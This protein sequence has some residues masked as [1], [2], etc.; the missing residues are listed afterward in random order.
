[1]SL[2]QGEPG[3][4]QKRIISDMKIRTSHA[5]IFL[6]LA[7]SIGPVFAVDMPA[8][9]DYP[10]HLAVMSV[11]SRN[12]TPAENPF[13][14][15]AWTFNTNLAMELVVPPLGRLIGLG[16]AGKAFLLLSQ[17]LV[18]GG[19]MAI[20]CV[21]RGRLELSPFAAALFLYSL[22]FAWGFLNFE[23]GLG[24]ALCAIAVWLRTELRPMFVRA[25]V[26]SIFVIVMFIAHLFALGIYGA[27]LGLHELW[28]LRSGRAPVRQTLLTMG[29]LAAPAVVVFG[30]MFTLGH[31]IA[32]GASDT[33]WWF[34]Y[35]PR[36]V[37]E[38]MNG[39]SELLSMAITALIIFAALVS[40]RRG[41]LKLVGSGAWIS[42]GFAVLYIA[43]P[44]RLFDAAFNDVRVV[45][46]AGLILPS[47]VQLS[48]AN[49]AWRRTAFLTAA[50]CAAANLAVVW[51]VWLSFRP[52]YAAIILSFQRITK[53]STVLVA[54]SYPAAQ[55]GGWPADYPF[56]HAPTLAVA[57]ANALVPSLFTVPGDRPAT[58]RPAYRQF[59]QPALYPAPE[60]SAL[61]GIAA[62]AYKDSPLYLQSWPRKYD[63]VYVLGP[64]VLNPM[65]LVLH[66]LSA[67]SRFVLYQVDK[68]AKMP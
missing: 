43:M 9:L 18:I 8:M 35:K 15:V 37:F 52:D 63:F 5:I 58:L 40:A 4:A 66:E 6:L 64:R 29:V 36:W 20:E 2:D 23:F 3:A 61:P 53:N 56:Y 17:L 30:I 60:V 46:A 10:N 44:G 1:M 50:G 47:F 27:T 26:H 39:Y 7:L 16:V 65:P 55:P 68:A 33:Q 19:A 48:F 45:T 24:V 49:L 38:A 31:S 13:Y 51:W 59:L 62:G 54:D 14:Q 25:L 57:Y 28:R 67:G 11:L 32:S 21:V 34:K 42:V 22:P 41:Y 12:G